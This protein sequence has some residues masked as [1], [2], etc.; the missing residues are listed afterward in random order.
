MHTLFVF[1]HQDD[2]IAAAA[3]ITHALR[4]GSV[5]CVYLTDGQ[6]RGVASRIRDEE[7]RVVLR[8]LGVDLQRVHFLGS[9]AQIADGHLVEHLGRALELLEAGVPEQVDEVFCLAYEGGHADHDA[10]HLVALAFAQRRG[11]DCYE[12]PLYHGFGLPGP[13]FNTLAPLRVGGAWTGRAIA[14]RDG[15]AIASLCRLYRSQW[16]TW[17]G[18]MPEALL[19]LVFGQKEW[20]RRADVARVHEKPHAGRLFY[21][22]RFGVEW[23]D[24][25]RHSRAFIDS[26]LATRATTSDQSPAR[27]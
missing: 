27:D 5:S 19:R 11:V 23:D 1:A 6:G 15:L 20:T 18:L 17:L 9:E 3:R 26:A 22:R 12:M 8:R 13:F 14:L 2:E 7:S 4:T 16:K 10:S 25:A 21:E 24:F